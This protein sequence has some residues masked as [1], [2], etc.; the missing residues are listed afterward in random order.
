M[1]FKPVSSRVNFPQ[2][3]EVILNRWESNNTFTKSVNQQKGK[4][5]FIFFEG[6]PTANGKP[7]S[8]HVEARVFKD[9]IPR[10]KTM[11]GYYCERKGGWDCHGM[12][13]ELEVE[14]KLGISGKPQ[15]DEYGVEKFC[16]LCR[17]SVFEYVEEWER[18]TERIGFWIDIKNS[19]ATMNNDFIE[20]AWWILKQSFDRGLLYEDYKV[21]PYCPR[22]GTSLSSHEL[23]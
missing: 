13:V 17:K 5:R 11:R 12:P 16:Q 20:S 9:L 23:P 15:I 19:Y 7:G 1:P 10:F 22:C 18:L 6:P 4:S 21:V 8:P 14:K 2:L 3:E